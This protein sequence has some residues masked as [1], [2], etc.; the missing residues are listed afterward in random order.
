MMTD[1]IIMLIYVIGAFKIPLRISPHTYL[2]DRG[3]KRCSRKQG[4]V[5][6]PF[7]GSLGSGRV[8][9]APFSRTRAFSYKT[10]PA[11]LSP[12]RQTQVPVHFYGYNIKYE[13]YPLKAQHR[14]KRFQL[15]RK[16]ILNPVWPHPRRQIQKPVRPSPLSSR[17]KGY[18]QDPTIPISPRSS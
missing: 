5:T 4:P 6:S 1:M 3:G 18:Q 8:H 14:N 12:N 11:T 16:T 17:S 13:R 10:R 7:K 15:H 2:F 9:A